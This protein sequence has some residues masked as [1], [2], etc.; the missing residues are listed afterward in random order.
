MTEKQKTGPTRALIDRL[1]REGKLKQYRSLDEM[2]RARDARKKRGV[3]ETPA[4]LL[5]EDHYRRRKRQTIT[6]SSETRALAKK[7]GNGNIS[8]GIERALLHWHD[9]PRTDRRRAKDH[10]E[11]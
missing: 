1:E 6:M 5:P 2:Q 7:I 8:G 11:G 10:S 9:C 4:H 3:Q